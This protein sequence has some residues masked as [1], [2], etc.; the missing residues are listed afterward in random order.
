MTNILG[1]PLVLRCGLVLGNRLVKSAMAESLATDHGLPT[2]R[3]A[4]LYERWAQ[5]GAG[6]LVTGNVMIDPEHRVA[7][8]DVVARADA[9]G[10]YAAWVASA[11]RHG[12]PMLMQLN[13]PGR[14]TPRRLCSH[15]VAPSSV[16]LER[17]AWLFAAPRALE[18]REIVGIVAR[19]A[20]A[21]ALAERSGFAGV[22]V[23]AAHGYLLSQFLSP[24]V[25]GRRD[26]YG[27]TAEARGRML[28]EVIRAIRQATSPGFA[29]AVKL[30][31]AD[32]ERGGLELA[33]S[34]AI[35]R[36]LDDEGIDLLEITGGTYASDTLLGRASP[37]REPYFAQ[38]VRA[39]RPQCAVPLI[40]TGGHRD[41]DRMTALVAAGAHDLV[42]LARPLVLVPDLPRRILA[43]ERPALA[44]PTFV[45]IPGVVSALALRWYTQRLQAL[46]DGA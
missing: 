44:E 23:H 32:F 13:H 43:G 9:L 20:N 26:G 4:R 46:A 34:I 14:Q 5:G 16:K 21:A 38:Y 36:R 24:K 37:E 41:P 1:G 25:N 35:A 30:N 12:V 45:P 29:L 2:P 42:G 8:G 22:E 27:G 28:V 17:A 15:P 6:L 10:S 31:A 3:H 18:E 11:S 39:L 33:E 40:L 7:A 19:F